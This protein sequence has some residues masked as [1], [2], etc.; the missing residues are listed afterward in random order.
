MYNGLDV[1]GENNCFYKPIFPVKI[2]YDFGIVTERAT[3]FKHFCS[4]IFVY[5]EENQWFAFGLISFDKQ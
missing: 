4:E 1:H 5:L 2:L 3:K